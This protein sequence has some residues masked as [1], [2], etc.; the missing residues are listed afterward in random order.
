MPLEFRRKLQLKYHLKIHSLKINHLIHD[1]IPR[2]TRP[3][4]HIKT[5]ANHTDCFATSANKIEMETGVDDIRVAMYHVSFPIDCHV[6]FL[7]TQATDKT[8]FPPFIK[9]IFEVAA[10]EHYPDHI[11]TFMDISQ[12]KQQQKRQLYG[13]HFGDRRENIKASKKS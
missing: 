2:E 13:W 9:I 7:I 11:K 3:G 4:Q 12:K 1:L 5:V 8:P 6:P 10:N